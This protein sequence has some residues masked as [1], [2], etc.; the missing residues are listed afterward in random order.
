MAVGGLLSPSG[1]IQSILLY[2]SMEEYVKEA[3]HSDGEIYRKMDL[4]LSWRYLRS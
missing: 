4:M 1:I 2:F 3:K